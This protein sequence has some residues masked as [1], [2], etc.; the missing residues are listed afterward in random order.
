LCGPRGRGKSTLLR[1]FARLQLFRSG[2]AEVNGAAIG[3]YRR[4]DLA[5]ALIMLAQFNQI[6]AGLMVC[7]LV[8]YSL[9]AYGG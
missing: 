2:Q 6:P 7:E 9:Y 3:T 4:Q 1:T 5:R 8:S